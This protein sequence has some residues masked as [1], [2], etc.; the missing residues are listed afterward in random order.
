MSFKQTKDSTKIGGSVKTDKV[1]TSTTSHD[2][3]HGSWEFFKDIRGL[4][5]RPLNQQISIP[6][7]AF[8]PDFSLPTKAILV[9]II[10][11][12]EV[13]TIIRNKV[14]QLSNA[15]DKDNSDALKQ[16]EIVRINIVNAYKKFKE[17]Q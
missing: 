13:L 7:T 4:V 11:A 1:N 16:K 10:K 9:N 12:K 17:E 6:S 2:Q 14:K 3:S 5:T 15:M 8:T